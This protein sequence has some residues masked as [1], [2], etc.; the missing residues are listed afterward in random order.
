MPHDVV[1]SFPVDTRKPTF[2]TNP[3]QRPDKIQ[4]KHLNFVEFL[5]TKA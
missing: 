5:A 3:K 1:I 4:E 2:P